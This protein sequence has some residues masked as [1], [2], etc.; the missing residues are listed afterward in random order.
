[1]GYPLVNV[2]I[3]PWKITIFHG[4]IHYF[5]GHFPLQ[6][7]S[8]PEGIQWIF[9][10]SQIQF[11]TI[12]VCIGE[13]NRCWNMLKYS[14]PAKV[15]G[16]SLRNLQI[17]CTRFLKTCC[18]GFPIATLPPF[19]I[20]RLLL[21]S[22]QA[23]VVSASMRW[24]AET[25]LIGSDQPDGT[26]AFLGCSKGSKMA[27]SDVKQF[28]ERAGFSWV[29]TLLPRCAP[30]PKPSFEWRFSG[31]TRRKL[32]DWS[33]KS[34]FEPLWDIQINRRGPSILEWGFLKMG[35]LE[36]HGFQY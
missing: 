10:F 12:F 4:K 11:L 17:W 13:N 21:R 15:A 8:S 36:D 22:V 3:L 35:D 34:L 2:Y 29:F 27:L 7:V 18:S 23:Q 33:E 26:A 30:N 25:Q 19:I 28:T 16:K 5:Y 1:M 32:A 14:L 6:T 24:A 31:L 9:D 20:H